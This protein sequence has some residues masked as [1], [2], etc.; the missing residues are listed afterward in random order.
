MQLLHALHALRQCIA[1]KADSSRESCVGKLISA[2][3]PAK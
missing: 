3:R 1:H 2:T